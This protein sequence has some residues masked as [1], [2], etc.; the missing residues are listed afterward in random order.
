VAAEPE[1]ARARADGSNFSALRRST[2]ADTR[3]SLTGPVPRVKPAKKDVAVVY[4]Y[5]SPMGFRYTCRNE[6]GMVIWDS[7][8]TYRSRFDA[9][10]AVTK[11]W[12][13]AKVTFER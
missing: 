7:Q 9:R 4:V 8:R 13:N 6:E 12:P 11:S 5:N 10:K 1:A 3:C 2:P